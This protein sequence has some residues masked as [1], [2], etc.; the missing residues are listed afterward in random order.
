MGR[1]GAEE[2]GR[3]PPL[4]R[5]NPCDWVPLYTAYTTCS[6]HRFPGG[7]AGFF[8][9]S[10]SSPKEGNMSPSKD[11]SEVV[12][13]ELLQLRTRVQG[14]LSEGWHPASDADDAY[15]SA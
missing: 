10:P 5:E 7:R 14:L 15:V 3:R 13:G 12:T 2:L 4:A 8:E 6:R 1:P 11:L 9:R